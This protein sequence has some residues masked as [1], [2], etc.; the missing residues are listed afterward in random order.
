M[1]KDSAI[2]II[3]GMGPEASAR[4]LQVMVAMASK[5]FEAREGTDFPE[6]IVDSIPVP[7]FISDEKNI[8]PALNMLK[9]RVKK[10]NKLEVSYFGIACNTAHILIASLASVSKA[11][12]VSMVE[13]VAREVFSQKIRKV[14]LLASPSTIKFGL[15]QKALGEIEVILPQDSQ[16]KYIESII[17]KIIALKNNSKDVQGLIDIAE[18]LRSRGAEGIILGCTELPIIFPKDNGFFIFD[19]VEILSRALLRKHYK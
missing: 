12:F 16:I 2:C 7:D 3:G 13:E 5:E 10:L 4:M 18:S 17:R 8:R 1:K 9:A 15:Y 11:P 19:S 14:G 6:I